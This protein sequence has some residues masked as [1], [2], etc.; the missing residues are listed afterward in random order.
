MRVCIEKST[1]RLVDWQSG[2]STELHLETLIENAVSLGNKQEDVE[3]KFIT[4]EEFKELLAGNKPTPKTKDE[5]VSK[6]LGQAKLLMAVVT[7]LNDGT[8]VPG[9][10]L[11]KDEVNSVIMASY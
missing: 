4:D 7:A 3:A 6:E 11:K 5:K 10:K 8:L 9:A 1:G 2:G